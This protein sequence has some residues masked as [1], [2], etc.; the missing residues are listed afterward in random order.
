MYRRACASVLCDMHVFRNRGQQGTAVDSNGQRAT[1]HKYNDKQQTTVHKYNNK[2]Q[3]T[4]NRQ[5]ATGNNMDTDHQDETNNSTITDEASANGTKLIRCDEWWKDIPR[6]HPDSEIVK[7]IFS[8]ERLQ[9]L[10]RGNTVEVRRRAEDNDA[11]DIGSDNNHINKAPRLMHFLKRNTGFRRTADGTRENEEG[12]GNHSNEGD[13]DNNSAPRLQP[14]FLIKNSFFRFR[15]T[16]DVTLENS[17]HEENNAPLA[18]NNTRV[19]GNDDDVFLDDLEL[20]EDIVFR[21]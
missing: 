7:S 5:Q 15:R 2:Q 21:V 20:G 14:L 8:A 6:F 9:M 4:G 19:V 18:N 11:S 13:I 12:S 10:L 1:V 17:Q 3:A 16:D